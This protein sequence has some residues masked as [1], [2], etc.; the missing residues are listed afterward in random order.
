MFFKIFQFLQAQQ[1]TEITVTAALL[2]QLALS[3]IGIK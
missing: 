1:A 3:N 2:V